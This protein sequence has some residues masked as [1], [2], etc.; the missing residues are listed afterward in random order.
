M[1]KANKVILFYN[2]YSGGGIF[3]PHLDKVIGKFQEKGMQVFP[4]KVD[5]EPGPM[6]E[7]LNS[8]DKESVCKV[9][10]CGGD[11]TVDICINALVQADYHAPLAI[12]PTGTANDL[13]N[14]LRI[15][16]VIEGMIDVALSDYQV[17]LDVGK[18]NDK[19]FIN[20]ASLGFIID[21]SQKTDQK[22]K[23]VLGMAG[24]YLKGIEEIPKTKP[25]KV[26]LKFDGQEITEDI[27][28]MLVMNGSTAGG[29]KNLAPKASTRDGVFDVVI[30]KDCLPIEFIN[31]ALMILRR[32]HINN[33]NVQFF[34]TSEIEINTDTDVGTDVD[35]E[36]G[37]EFPLNIKILPGRFN[38]CVPMA[39]R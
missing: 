13:A 14:H 39:I 24:Y 19:Y 34:Q 2:S 18:I 33:R 36:K 32:E 9:I 7:Y 27:L 20:E 8:L 5:R 37:P 30:F 6:V 28:F 29:F 22:V 16:R 11:G 26:N 1:K 17:P 12:F 23:N 21:V 25:F 15:P 3:P 4:Y 38:V 10:C 35:G 31:V